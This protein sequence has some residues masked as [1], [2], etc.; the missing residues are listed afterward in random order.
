MHI[1]MIGCGQMG[2]SLALALAQE[3]HG[4]KITL[5]D[6]NP[7]HAAAILGRTS[8]GALGRVRLSENLGESVAIADIVVLATALDLFSP[9][10][11]AIAPH[12]KPGT[13]ITDVGSGKTVAIA[14][15]EEHLPDGVF[16]VPAH[17]NI[18]RSGSGPATADPAMFRGQKIVIIPGH[19]PPTA[20]ETIIALWRSTGADI[21]TMD[22]QTHDC[23]Y[24]TVSH[25]QHLT[26][27]ALML[28]GRDGDIDT[29]YPD[30]DYRRAGNVLRDLT[31]IANS[32]PQMWTAIF[33]DNRD[34]ILD[35]ATTFRRILIE[36]S[37]TGQ[38][39]ESLRPY[40][41]RAHR[42]IMPM[43]PWMPERLEADLAD[44][45][46]TA[47]DD[48][49]PDQ[50]DRVTARIFTLPLFIELATALNAIE[51][52]KKMHGFRIADMPNPSFLDGTRGLTD[53]P[54][55][56]ASYLSTPTTAEEYLGRGLADFLHHFD[57]A[58]IAV[59]NGESRFLM[60]FI[61]TA[62]DMRPHMPKHRRPAHLIR[63]GEA[64]P[65]RPQ[66]LAPV[67]GIKA[68]A[69]KSI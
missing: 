26:V 62:R 7:H 51:T 36:I 66:M 22:A 61:A 27:F 25:L 47:P 4:V 48:E 12:L 43:H 13:I 45:A 64:E 15:I 19:A 6:A 68:V 34:A 28:A 30:P 3:N 10:M 67:M 56:I 17:P 5:H 37:T 39:R 11:A 18:G 24:G 35:S 58:V 41:E 60:N 9:I 33:Q 50:R 20:L 23:F 54:D 69:R 21:I 1:L 14:A 44:I 46:A 55:T 52:E 8:A 40:I 32:G 63:G 53:D 38:S 16:L 65:L 59:Q 49:S 29:P 57:R 42:Y 2:G 31:R